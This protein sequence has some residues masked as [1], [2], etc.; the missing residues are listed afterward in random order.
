VH[1]LS[2][3]TRFE[4]V[5]SVAR[6]YVK[7]T[8]R[9]KLSKEKLTRTGT[10]KNRTGK[11]HYIV[12]D[13]GAIPLND[14]AKQY[15]LD[16]NLGYSFFKIPETNKI[17]I[18]YL[19]GRPIDPASGA[20]IR[21]QTVDGKTFAVSYYPCATA[22][23]AAT[24]SNMVK[25]EVSDAFIDA[26]SAKALDDASDLAAKASLVTPVGP[27]MYTAQG[28][29]TAASYSSAGI[30]GELT[31]QIAEEGTTAL[32]SL[33]IKELVVPGKAEKIEVLLD[34]L[35]VS[36]KVNETIPEDKEIKTAINEYFEDDQ[37][38]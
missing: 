9:F 37:N 23:C 33:I 5:Q 21:P 25:N 13:M 28:I 29:G 22:E 35:D 27:L 8:L 24:N 34:N 4:A 1:P 7:Y 18:D 38:K 26:T 30:K 15:L 6:R 16:K 19:T 10:I 17:V 11:G 2:I 12:Q 20:Y 32:F 3:Q 31:K 14:S 36:K